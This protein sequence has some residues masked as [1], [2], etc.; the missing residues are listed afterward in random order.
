MKTVLI[1]I[2]SLVVMSAFSQQQIGLRGGALSG[3]SYRQFSDADHC[4]EVILADRYNG[5][6]FS[7]LTERFK[8][9]LIEHSE[10]I[11]MYSGFGAHAGFSS[12]KHYLY[13]DYEH[14]DVYKLRTGPLVGIDFVCGL[15]YRFNRYPITVGLDYNPY[16]EISFADIFRVDLWN[17]GTS[18]R[19][20][21]K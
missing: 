19:Y 2:F 13:D 9:V 18:V 1:L 5:L 10:N 6:Q 14:D 8:P 15:E 4:V 17:F 7:L 12:S 16:A 20:T 3:I 11:F 21:F